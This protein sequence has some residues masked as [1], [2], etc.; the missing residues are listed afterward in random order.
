MLVPVAKSTVAAAQ[1][2][3]FRFGDKGTHTSRTL[4]LEEL[5]VVLA[6]TKPEARRADYARAIID[7]NCL[8]KPTLSTRRLSNQ[9]LGELYGLDA[10]IPVFRVLRRLWD[11][12]EAGRPLLALLCALARDPL[13]AATAD[14]VVPLLEGEEFPRARTRDLLR[15]AVGPRLNDSILDKVVRNA[16]SSW[17]QAG[18][19]QGRTFKKRT[20]VR[21]TPA[22]VAYALYLGYAVGFR[23]TELFSSGWLSVL[24]T[25]PVEAR[26]LA[27]E[28]KRFGL[29]DLNI[30]DGI[31]A[32]GLE[33]LE[34]QWLRS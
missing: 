7:D 31:V 29:I 9:R 10:G 12:D 1:A 25:H 4:M 5:R 3:G 15:Q 14:A 26:A 20:R 18:H 24:D 33:R 11:L 34:P 21:G 19:L 2:L 23:G 16:A 32:L 30:S 27:M 17:A 13:L 22:T 8:T 28:A 6:A